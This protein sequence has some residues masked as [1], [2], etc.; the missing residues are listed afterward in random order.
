MRRRKGVRRSV[1]LGPVLLLAAACGSLIDV[2]EGG[3]I[4]FEDLD[5]AGPSGVPALVNG[6][7][8]AYQEALDDVVRYATLMTDEMIMSGTFETRVD[9]DRR[10]IQPSNETLTGSI[11]TQIHVARMQADTRIEVGG[12]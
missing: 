10:R 2:D 1:A 9:V 6:I 11:Y 12:L 5:E 4:D 8:G 7:V 3:V